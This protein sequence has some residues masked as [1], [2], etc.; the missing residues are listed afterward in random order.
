[1]I[2]KNHFC[3]ETRG[4]DPQNAKYQSEWLPPTGVLEQPQLIPDGT[5][6]FFEVQSYEEVN[7][8]DELNGD[9]DCQ[10]RPAWKAGDP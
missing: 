1:M 10:S 3:H 5:S 7:N 6:T 2:L 4:K 8:K 9:F